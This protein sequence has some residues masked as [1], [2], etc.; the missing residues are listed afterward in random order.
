M[1]AINNRKNTTAVMYGCF[2]TV[3]AIFFR[4]FII[5]SHRFLSQSQRLDPDDSDVLMLAGELADQVLSGDVVLPEKEF[6]LFE[7]SIDYRTI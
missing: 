4:N 2:F 5:S 7:K 1:I 3:S 6:G